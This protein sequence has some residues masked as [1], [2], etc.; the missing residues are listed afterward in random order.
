[1]F[2][3]SLILIVLLTL[4]DQLIK[5]AVVKNIPLYEIH[6]V[7]RVGSHKIFSLT[8]VKND[9]AAW[10]IM[11]GKSWFLIGIPIIII[12]IGLFFLYKKRHESKFLTISLSVLISGGIGNLIDRIRFHEVIDYIKFEPIDFPVFNFAD[13]CVVIGGILFCI[14]FIIIDEIN[15]KRKLTAEQNYE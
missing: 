2:I 11:A 10:S 13:I 6:E 4:V 7:I 9:G 3:F 8:H 12:L 15:K 1:M 5:L 14:Y